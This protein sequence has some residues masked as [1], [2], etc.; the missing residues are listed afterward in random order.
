M[1]QYALFHVIEVVTVYIS[2]TTEHEAAAAGGVTS[3]R[4]SNFTLLEFNMCMNILYSMLLLKTNV[5]V[6][7]AS[8]NV[9]INFWCLPLSCKH[10]V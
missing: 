4:P 8:V 3:Y 5:M 1:L 6:T 2:Y 10:T 9:C 7:S